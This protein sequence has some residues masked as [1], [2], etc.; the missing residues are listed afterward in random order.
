MTI[1][2]ANGRI[3]SVGGA[4]VLRIGEKLGTITAGKLADLV[5]IRG[6]L[7]AR[8]ADIRKVTTVFGTPGGGDPVKGSAETGRAAE[9]G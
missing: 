5:V 7:L 8:P 3:Q 4:K 2:I 1:A 9:D 6:D